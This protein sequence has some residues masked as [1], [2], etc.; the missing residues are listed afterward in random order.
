MSDFTYEKQDST[1]EL[2]TY[3]WDN[4]WWEQAPARG[5]ERVLY[6]GDSISCGIRRIATEKAGGKLLF[7]GFGTSKA[8]DNPYFQESLRLFA[9][10]QAERRL[11][12]FNNGLHGFHLSDTEQ[13]KICYEKMVQFLLEEFQGTPLALVLTTDIEEPRSSRVAARNNV[14]REL[15]EK[16]Q[17][18]VIDLY[19][20]S[21]EIA[22]LH[23]GDGIHFVQEGCEKL[24]EKLVEE[25]F[26][27]LSDSLPCR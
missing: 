22:Q 17:L 10:Q 24:A 16:Y 8:V 27:I 1:Q 11:V 12:I 19:T 26:E 5:K 21:E 2:E 13:Y 14:V 23:S 25:V 7:D 9:R 6:I 18:P 20:V 3:E 4:V 15:A